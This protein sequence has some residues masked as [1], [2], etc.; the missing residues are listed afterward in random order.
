[1]ATNLVYDNRADLRLQLTVGASKTAG[2]YIAL[3]DLW[4]LLLEDSDSNNKATCILPGLSTVAN[5]SVVGADNA[6][7]A[8]VA[9][10]AKVYW[11]AAE[12]NVDATNGT[13]VGYALEAVSSGETTTIQ[14][15]LQNA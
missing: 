13:F 5:L 15:A 11:D 4:V 7:N 3:N 8:A 9:V 10:G 12:F 14:V 2:S 1:M 6:G